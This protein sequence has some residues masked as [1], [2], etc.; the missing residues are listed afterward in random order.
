MLALPLQ[1][2]P[3]LA[4]SISRYLTRTLVP[5]LTRLLTLSLTPT[6]ASVL[7]VLQDPALRSQTFWAPPGGP[8]NPIA[9]PALRGSAAS[10]SSSVPASAGAD[11]AV[12]WLAD[13][14]ARMAQDRRR[15][16]E[17]WGSM[18]P[19][20]RAG[21]MH[22]CG[23]CHG[24]LLPPTDDAFW[25]PTH[26]RWP[27]SKELVDS[28]TR[29]GTIIARA[30]VGSTRGAGDLLFRALMREAAGKGKGWT[31]PAAEAAAMT[32]FE[33]PQL[34]PSAPNAAQALA[35]PLPESSEQ[36]RTCHGAPL[37]P[38]ATAAPPRA[39]PPGTSVAGW[40][41]SLPAPAF[42]LHYYGHAYGDRYGAYMAD[43][44]AKAA[45]AADTARGA[46]LAA[47]EEADAAA[48]AAKLRAELRMSGNTRRAKPS[49]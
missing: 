5:S 10:G 46:A 2:S 35:G 22:A 31:D 19:K 11:A 3:R 27:M 49:A 4:T 9:A 25:R 1:L 36:C 37:I 29:N 41:G 15:S 45:V 17:L 30:D 24:L 28:L 48:L 7:D 21:R 6:L 38:T 12:N 16:Y 18:E 32:Q 14:A 26:A 23:A 43:Y 47:K 8:A 34:G 20:E 40:P 42:L 33:L 44:F 13:A 39:P